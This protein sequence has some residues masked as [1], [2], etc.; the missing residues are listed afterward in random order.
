M[1]QSV[2]SEDEMQAFA[3]IVAKNVSSGICLNLIGDVGTGKTTFTKGF[4]RALGVVETVQSPTFTISR[5][6]ETSDE[7]QLVH[8][9]FYRLSE[10]GIM[11]EEL[12]E[13]LDNDAI[14]VIEWGDI[15]ADI[16]P[17][18][19][20]TIYIRSTSETGREVELAANGAHSEAV[21]DG[22]KYAVT[23]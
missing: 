5:V 7:R 18:D 16:L 12:R 9:D 6:Y 11:S 22:V 4:A 17:D 2:N 14:V 20:L 1:Q 19:S 13:N 15:V 8:Y 10:P 23:A 21:L 3:A